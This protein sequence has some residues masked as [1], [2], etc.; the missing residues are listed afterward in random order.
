M[1]PTHLVDALAHATE[2]AGPRAPTRLREWLADGADPA[3]A[4]EAVDA[5][6]PDD[7]P[8]ELGEAIDEIL[9]VCP[10]RPR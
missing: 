10:R 8:G 4:R 7:L 1:I 5:F 3:T 6:D 9:A 2:R